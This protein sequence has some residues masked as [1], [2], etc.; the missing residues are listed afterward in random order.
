MEYVWVFLLRP[1]NSAVQQTA[2]DGVF[3]VET[4]LRFYV[5]IQKATSTFRLTQVLLQLLG[6][7]DLTCQYDMGILLEHLRSKQKSL[8][9]FLGTIMTLCHF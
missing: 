8:I 9:E 6:W 4:R 5:K 2:V 3:L 7:V 1:Y